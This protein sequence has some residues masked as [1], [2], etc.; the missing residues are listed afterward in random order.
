MIV[1]WAT[2]CEEITGTCL[3]EQQIAQRYEV[4]EEEFLDRVND[5]EVERCDACGWW[6]EINE[7]DDELV[8]DD[9]RE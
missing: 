5:Y 6:S 4:D 9:C 7:L 3:S 8:C 1:D 2:I